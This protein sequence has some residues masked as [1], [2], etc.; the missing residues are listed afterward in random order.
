MKKSKVVRFIK[1]KAE[2]GQECI[3]CNN[4]PSRIVL[5]SDW[6]EAL[7]C[8]DCLVIKDKFKHFSK[9]PQYR[10]WNPFSAKEGQKSPIQNGSNA[11]LQGFLEEER[12]K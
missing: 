3:Y 2:K 12:R 9:Q 10:G 5:Y 11:I 4:L 1:I 8:E 6:T 7:I